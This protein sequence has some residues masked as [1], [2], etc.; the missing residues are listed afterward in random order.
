[1]EEARERIRSATPLHHH[2]LEER[3][4]R[5]FPDR[6]GSYAFAEGIVY[7]LAETGQYTEVYDHYR[8]QGM[9]LPSL[10]DRP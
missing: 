6:R 2:E 7:A 3:V 1:M 5:I 4:Y 9:N 10:E 8:R